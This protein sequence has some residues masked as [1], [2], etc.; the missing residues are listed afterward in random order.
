MNRG[1]ARNGARWPSPVSNRGLSSNAQAS[2]CWYEARGA[3]RRTAA[4]TASR[5]A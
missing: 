5:L 3:E 2:F 1:I 4:A